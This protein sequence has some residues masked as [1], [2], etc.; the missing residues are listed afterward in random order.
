[1]IGLTLA[2][3][4]VVLV[5]EP[6]G[7]VVLCLGLALLALAVNG[8]LRELSDGASHDPPRRG[9]TASSEAALVLRVGR[10]LAVRP[11]LGRGRGDVLL[12]AGFTLSRVDGCSP[13]CC[14]RRQAGA[15]W[16]PSRAGREGWPAGCGSPPRRLVPSRRGPVGLPWEDVSASSR[17]SRCR[18][19]SIPAASPRST[20]R[21]AG[22]FRGREPADGILAIN[23]FLP[24]GQC[25][26]R[27]SSARR[28]LT[29]RSGPRSARPAPSRRPPDTVRW[30][31]A[32]APPDFVET[33]QGAAPTASA[34][35][36]A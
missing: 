18:C 12:G 11:R 34:R 36:S 4:G 24:G 10:P 35:G 8:V 7:P 13:W 26:R 22:R 27:T 32:K 21:A 15:C 6:A 3:L 25:W 19:S 28:S 23:R 17:R 1:M 9:W 29:R 31:T 33:A 30:S 14:S 5:A 16:W 20:A 2:G